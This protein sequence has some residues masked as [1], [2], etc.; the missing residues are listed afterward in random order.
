MKR[1]DVGMLFQQRADDVALHAFAFAVDQTH[2]AKTGLAAL[3][4]IF[5]DDAGYFLWLKWMEIEVILDGNDNGIDEW[6]FRLAHLTAG[7]T[8]GPEVI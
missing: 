7:S 1:L 8:T 5:L 6:R 4:K 3:L 2:F